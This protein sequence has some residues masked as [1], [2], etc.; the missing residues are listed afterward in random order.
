MADR[1]SSLGRTGSWVSA[2]QGVTAVAST[3][4]LIGG[5]VLFLWSNYTALST[6]SERA[7]A[8]ER[9]DHGH[10]GPPKEAIEE[11]QK[12]GLPDKT[13]KTLRST[14]ALAQKLSA[15]NRAL[16]KSV[17]KMYWWQIGFTAAEVEPCAP[18][19]AAATTFYREEFSRLMA[20]PDA[21]PEV[22][23]REALNVR[24]NDRRKLARQARCR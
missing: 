2:H 9:Y 20:Q 21:K 11:W 4:G 24:W 7:N 16:T 22:A 19:R 17:T 15:E 10:V 3:V 1:R 23:F 8:I 13:R 14:E 5:A 18:I 6:D 12:G